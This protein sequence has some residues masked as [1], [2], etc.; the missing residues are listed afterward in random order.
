MESKRGQVPGPATQAAMLILVI[1][2]AIILYILMLP[3]DDRADLL[4]RTV[5]ISLM[6]SISSISQ[7]F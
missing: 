2:I 7:S 6:A 4:G 1:G 3:P 5:H